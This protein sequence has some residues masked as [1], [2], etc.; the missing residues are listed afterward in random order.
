MLLRNA[1]L[2]ELEFGAAHRREPRLATPSVESLLARA[3][4][5]AAPGE[6][7]DPSTLE[8]MLAAMKAFAER[9]LASV[10]EQKWRSDYHHAAWLVVTCVACDPTDHTAR[11]AA[12]LRAEYR[13]YPALRRALDRAGQR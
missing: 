8:P 11:W 12:A 4:V 5:L 3:G 1:S 13:R 6:V 10:T 9:R 2:D 7:A